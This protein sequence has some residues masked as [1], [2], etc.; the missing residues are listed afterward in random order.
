MIR[1]SYFE[2]DPL[3]DAMVHWMH[4]TGMRQAWPI[5]ELALTKGLQAVVEPHLAL[6]DFFTSVERVPE[7]VRQDA[8]VS[9]C[10]MGVR[11]SRMGELISFSSLLGGYA[12][13]GLAKPLVATRS[14]DEIAALRLVET[15][16]WVYDVYNSS[17][18]G[19]FSNGFISTVRVR[20]LHALVRNNLVTKGWDQERWGLP[21]NQV[22]M[23]ATLLGFS[24][25]SLIGLRLMGML[26]T[27]SE[28]RD[29]MCLWRYVGYL[30]GV[31]D[32]F[33]PSTEI[34]AMK[35][36][37][38]LIGSQEGPDDDSRSLA[39]SLLNTR[40]TRWP[41]TQIGRICAQCDINFRSALTCIMS[42]R[43]ASDG[44]QLPN[45]VFWKAAVL[46]LPIA[47]FLPEIGRVLIPGG[48]ARATER[49]RQRFTRQLLK[50]SKGQRTKGLL[51]NN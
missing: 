47:N 7:W 19:R 43:A 45:S 3:A 39:K 29:F 5:F 44:L 42:G 50:I 14:L 12:A 46:V 40:F 51:N 4:K 35:L 49:G 17:G 32:K 48:T 15:T 28:G 26:I 23:G 25:T 20:V 36:I 6:K 11:T 31:D 1:A 22:D 16:Q 27:P 21:I 38:M 34:D 9:G 33:N 8:L 2:G 24:I 18:L 37:P 41:E 30:I 13:V 10:D